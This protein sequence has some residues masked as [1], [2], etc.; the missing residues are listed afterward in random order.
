MTRHIGVIRSHFGGH[1]VSCLLEC[2]CAVMNVLECFLVGHGHSVWAPT[3][4]GDR[5]WP[6]CWEM[7][8]RS[9]VLCATQQ[10][11]VLLLFSGTVAAL[12]GMLSSGWT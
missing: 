4:G 9:A 7:L 8:S 1:V 10:R 12:A 6:R 11:T 5:S 2:H 3:C